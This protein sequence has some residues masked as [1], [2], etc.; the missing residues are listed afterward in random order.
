MDRQSLLSNHESAALSIVLASLLGASLGCSGVS[1]TA[2]VSS[3]SVTTPPNS[4]ADGSTSSQPPASEAGPPAADEGGS[5]GDADLSEA[6]ALADAGGADDAALADDAV[7]F[8]A[9]VL[10]DSGTGIG[11]SDAGDAASSTADA[12]A[13]TLLADVVFFG[14]ADNAPPSNQIAYP[15]SAGFPT[16]HDV[17]EGAGTYAD[18]ITFGGDSKTFPPGTILYVPYIGKYVVLEDEC[19]QCATQALTTHRPEIAVWMASNASSPPA[20]VSNCEASWTRTAV[21]VVTNP[22]SGSLVTTPPLFDPATRICR[23]KP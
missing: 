12:A 10:A 21:P 16:K 11:S 2:D 6:A 22:P 7:A 5:A 9:G 4:S 15:K 17:A 1:P 14:W 8:D 23:T 20:S 3:L 19:T 13:T 18:P